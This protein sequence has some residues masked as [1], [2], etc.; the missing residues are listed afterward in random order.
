MLIQAFVAD[1]FEQV[2]SEEI[3]DVLNGLAGRWLE[4]STKDLAHA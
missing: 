2:S 4:G 3:R 1:A